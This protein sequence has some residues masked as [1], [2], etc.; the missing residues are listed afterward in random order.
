[1][2]NGLMS[3]NEG[4]RTLGLPPI[5]GGDEAFVR[6]REGSAVKVSDLPNITSRLKDE[7]LVYNSSGEVQDLEIDTQEEEITTED[8]SV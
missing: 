1:M 3:I 5:K 7:S 4:R 2:L 8:D 6:V